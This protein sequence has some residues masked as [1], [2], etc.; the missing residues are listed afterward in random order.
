MLRA[1]RVLSDCPIR[2]KCAWRANLLLMR[3][4]VPKARPTARSHS[5]RVR[6]ATPVLFK[7]YRQEKFAASSM[8]PLPLYFATLGYAH[9][10]RVRPAGTVPRS[11][12]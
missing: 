8:L 6:G 3:Q 12:F 7:P 4:A 1:G 2:K 5:P 9:N 11:A 10:G